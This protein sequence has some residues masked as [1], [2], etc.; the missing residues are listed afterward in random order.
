MFEGKAVPIASLTADQY[1]LLV[2]GGDTPVQKRPPQMVTPFDRL[3]KALYETRVAFDRKLID[4]MPATVSSGVVAEFLEGDRAALAQLK[5]A[6][7]AS[8]AVLGEMPVIVLTRGRDASNE[9]QAAHAEISRMSRNSR[10]LVIPDVYHEIHLSH[11]GAVVN[12]ITDVLAAVRST[13]ALDRY[14]T[15]GTSCV[16]VVFSCGSTR[17]PL[18]RELLHARAICRSLVS[19]RPTL[20]MS[21]RRIPASPRTVT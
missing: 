19:A 11:P 3:P 7:Q 18:Q 20:E 16:D 17:G 1:R 10:H 6:R 4:S 9:L 15:G 5:A 13:V 21:I 14:V 8:A 12:A 2:P